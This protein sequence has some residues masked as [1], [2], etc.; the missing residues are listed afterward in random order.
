[1]A[2]IALCIAQNTSRKAW[3]YIQAYIINE[4][5]LHLLVENFVK[6]NRCHHNILGQETAYLE[7]LRV[8]V[9][10][11]QGCGNRE[12][13]CGSKEERTRQCSRGSQGKCDCRSGG[14]SC[15][16]GG[17]DGKRGVKQEGRILAIL[18]LFIFG[19]L[20]EETKKY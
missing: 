5:R 4:G 9:E 13:A 12:G 10:V 14:S 17:G 1:M 6:I 20:G 18:L 2:K 15:G 7:T 11:C 19:T 16:W 8:K 3:S